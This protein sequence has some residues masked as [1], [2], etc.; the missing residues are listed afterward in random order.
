MVAFE[1][2]KNDTEI[3]GKLRQQLRKRALKC[4][5]QNGGNFENVLKVP[6]R[7]SANN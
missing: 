4:I 1:K 5:E 6:R 3:L 7:R 2:V